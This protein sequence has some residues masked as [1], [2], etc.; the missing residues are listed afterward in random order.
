MWTSLDNL[1]NKKKN[2]FGGF[3][4]AELPNIWKEAI[5]K[6]YPEA[7]EYAFYKELKDNTLHIGVTDTV[8]ISELSYHQEDLKEYIN[9]KRKKAIHSL[10][11][12]LN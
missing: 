11:I 4:E 3:E 10:R 7:A 12:T 5:Q 9:K 1:L 2:G 6:V 8:W